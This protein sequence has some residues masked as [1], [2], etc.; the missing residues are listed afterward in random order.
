MSTARSRSISL[1]LTAAL[2]SATLSALTFGTGAA[3]ASATTSLVAARTTFF[4]STNVNQ[5][6]GAVRADRIIASWVGVSTFAFAIRGHVVLL[7][8]WIPDIYPSSV[9][10]T[11]ADLAALKPERIFLGHGHFDHALDAVSIARASGATVVGTAEHCTALRKQWKALR[12]TS[13]SPAGA[14][15]GST[16]SYTGLSGVSVKVL[17]N[18]HSG[19]TKPDGHF[20]PFLP[21]PPSLKVLTSISDLRGGVD[22]ITHFLDPEGGALIYRFTVNGFDLVWH[23]SSGPLIDSKGGPK[24]IAALKRWAPVN[25]EFGAIQGY[26]EFTNGFRD[27]VT[28][29]SALRPEV[30]VPNHHD[31]WLP[32]VSVPADQMAGAFRTVLAK[33]STKPTLRYL[34]DPADYVRPGI[35]T[36]KVPKP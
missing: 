25:V 33:A 28:Y 27:P 22:T 12:C 35:L 11:P 5:R 15:L 2:M 6:T 4:G 16:S 19:I 8:A 18:L 3:P 17:R 32:V 30:F 14:A 29:I 23:D 20:A 26:N 13:V 10:A 1:V 34:T 31:N 24:V 9:P 36:W 21:V 7:D